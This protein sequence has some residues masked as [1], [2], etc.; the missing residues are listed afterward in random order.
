MRSGPRSGL[1]TLSPTVV[2]DTTRYVDGQLSLEATRDRFDLSAVAGYR[3]G[4]R[5]PVDLSGAKSW[6]SFSA[7]GWVT[8]VWGVVAAAG[9]YPVDPTQGF[10]GGRFISV[11][12]RLASARRNTATLQNFGLKSPPASGSGESS[13]EADVFRVVKNAQGGKVLQYRAPTATR[14]EMTGDFTQ[15]VPVSL[16]R[17]AD[18][19]WTGELPRAAGTYQMNLRVDGGPWIVPPGMLSMKDEFGGVT[20][21]LVIE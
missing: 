18:G 14:V 13:G 5:L 2:D 20:G 12:V 21:L 17:S 6:M 15:W 9:T 7:T 10:P 16:Q 19:W 11:G 4:S 3:R 8:P 1:V